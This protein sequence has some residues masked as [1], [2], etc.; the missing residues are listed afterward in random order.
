M[1]VT[2]S[3]FDNIKVGYISETDGYIKDVSI[4]DANAYAQL[5][6]ETEFIFIDGSFFGILFNW[7][8][9]CSM[10]FKYK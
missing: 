4:A 1:P 5:N 9:A 7:I 8:F 2:Q 6:P 10:W 3:S